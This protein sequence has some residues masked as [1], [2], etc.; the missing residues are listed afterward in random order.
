M[1]GPVVCDALVVGAGPAGL[2]AAEVLSAA[3]HSVIVADAMP[4][5]ARKFLMAGK[6]GLNL[7]KIEPEEAFWAAFEPLAPQ[8]G[9]ALR[10][11]GPHDVIAWAEGLGQPV[12]TGSSGRVFP[13]VM[14]ASPLLRAWLARL[15]QNGVRL[16]RRW[17]LVEL[18]RVCVFETPN[19]PC[20]VE[21]NRVIL[22]LGG[23]SWA[24]L[25]STG[26]WTEVLTP[27]AELAPLLPANAALDVPWSAHMAPHF[28]SP[29]KGVALASGRFHSR[30]EFVITKRGLEGG[31]IYAVSRGVREGAPL[32]VDLLPDWSDEKLEKTLIQ[33]KP[34][35]SV[36]SFL[37][38][39]LR[40]SPS[41][42][43]LF[44]EFRD[45]DGPLDASLKRLTVT[46]VALRPMDEAISTAGGVTFDSLDDGLALKALPHVHVAGEMLDWEAPTGGYLLTACFAT[47]RLAAIA[48]SAALQASRGGST[49]AR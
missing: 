35:E 4:S 46:P 11:F 45:P 1:T 14:K 31:G 49:P 41:K 32:T 9:A 42:A 23:G 34:K 20:A 47:G 37:R 2:M 44:M 48:A 13:K 24:R 6:S 33:R 28:G 7:T 17:R 25:G 40:L 3:G 27:Y 43:A 21:A 39:A 10:A 15:D 36:S 22:A 12:F 38:K 26:R 30:G 16:E 18:G 19:G 29:V 8:L 5:A